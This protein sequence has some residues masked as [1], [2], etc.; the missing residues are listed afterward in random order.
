MNSCHV[1]PL[2]EVIMRAYYRLSRCAFSGPAMITHLSSLENG[3][4]SGI[5][6]PCAFNVCVISIQPSLHFFKK[7]FTP[8]VKRHWSFPAITFLNL[9]SINRPD[10]LHFSIKKSIGYPWRFVLAAP[11]SCFSLL[12]YSFWLLK[13]L[14]PRTFLQPCRRTALS[15]RLNLIC[16]E[17]HIPPTC[18]ILL[19]YWWHAK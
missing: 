2:I 11:I 10:R 16:W 15:Y 7:R 14:F 9:T 19:T 3:S 18:P 1:F 17:S 8:K 4:V 13:F 6:Y 12:V 5:W